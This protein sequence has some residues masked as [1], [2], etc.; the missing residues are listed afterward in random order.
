M[1]SIRAA[2][3]FAGLLTLSG[4]V[5][6]PDHQAPEMVLPAKF[7]EGGVKSNGDIAM[8]DWWTAFRDKRL[9]G[10]VVQGQEQNLTILQALERI[11]AAEANVVS[12][13]AGALPQGQLGA[14]HTVSGQGGSRNLRT[15]TDVRNISSGSLSVS[16][17]LDLFGQ[18]ARARESA[19]ASLD[20]A[21]ADIDI[22][23]LTLLSNV[24]SAYIDARYYQELLAISRK[25]LASRRE[26]LNLTRFQLEAG[27]ASRL[28]VVQAEGLVNSTLSEIPGLETRFRVSVHRVSTLLG[29][30]ASTLIGDMQKSGGQPVARMNVRAG[31]PADLIRNRPDIRRAERELAAAVANIGVAEAQL[32][33]SITL[34][35]SIQPS[36]LGSSSIKGGLVNWSFGPSITLPILDGGRL[37]AGVDIAK[38][39]AKTQYLVWKATV[40]NG[41]EEVENALAAVSRDA[42]TV[43]ALRAQ[44]RSYEEALTL[45]TASYK[46]G[47]SSLLDVLDAQR[48]VSA[49]QTSL[50]Q[51]IQQQARDYVSLNVAIGGGYSPDGSSPAVQKVVATKTTKVV[52]AN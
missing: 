1:M 41:V 25:N 8:K 36:Y 39:N 3:A 6:G 15:Q 42:Q 29:L 38:S 28:D 33:P 5:V 9:N 48:Q 11:N 27:A 23:R 20:A 13:G 12:A 45:A 49:A 30:P 51:A 22:A 46:D 4:C 40:L 19:V 43:S 14:S 52:V 21:Y 37:K 50:A 35:G 47:A 18:Y 10:Y 7:A 24:V 44:V 26:T 32:Y 2:A 16:W 34:G 31:V 17:L